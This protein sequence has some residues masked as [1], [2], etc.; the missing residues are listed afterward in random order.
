[1]KKSVLIGIGIVI[2]ICVLG[3]GVYGLI[4]RKSGKTSREEYVRTIFNSINSYPGSTVVAEGY[5][6]DGVTTMS[7]HNCG[8]IQ[9]FGLLEAQS[10]FVDVQT[11]YR[12][13]FSGLTWA[14]DQSDSSLMAGIDQDTVVYVYE[15]DVG[16]VLRFK[17]P[18]ELYENAQKDYPTLFFIEISNKQHFL[19]N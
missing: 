15:A 16:P 17:I 12:D 8:S 4:Q 10:P 11:Y 13:L 19:C 1:M 14:I 5:H 7:S 3:T 2:V 9:Y 6:A 18:L